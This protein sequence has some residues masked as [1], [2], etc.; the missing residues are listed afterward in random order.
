M[1]QNLHALSEAKRGCK[2]FQEDKMC[3]K[4]IILILKANGC[5]RCNN[6]YEKD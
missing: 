5:W 4:L 2:A 1:M 3:Y 6:D